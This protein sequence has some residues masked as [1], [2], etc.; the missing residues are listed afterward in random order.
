MEFNVP[1]KGKDRKKGSRRPE[2]KLPG[3]REPLI[4]KAF[5]LFL[6]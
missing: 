3:R 6:I 2:Q 1:E 5:Q 4:L